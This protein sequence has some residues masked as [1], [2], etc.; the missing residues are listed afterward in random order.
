MKIRSLSFTMGSVLVFGSLLDDEAATAITAGVAP[1][2]GSFRP[3]NS[4]RASDG[5][6]E[7]GYRRLPSPTEAQE[8]PGPC[9]PGH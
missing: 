4:L 9:S 6:N 2:T 5:Q 3:Q 1:F 7:Q 8:R